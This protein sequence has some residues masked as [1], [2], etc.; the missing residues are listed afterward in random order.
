MSR[1]TFNE[2]IV[3]CSQGTPQFGKVV[4]SDVLAPRSVTKFSACFWKKP[5]NTSGHHPFKKHIEKSRLNEQTF[6]WKST[7]VRYGC[8]RIFSKG[9]PSASSWTW[10][11]PS[12]R[13]PKAI[14]PQEATSAG[15][16]TD[17][18]V[19][20]VSPLAGASSQFSAWFFAAISQLLL[21]PACC[22]WAFTYQRLFY[23]CP[24]TAPVWYALEGFVSSFVFVHA[25][26]NEWFSV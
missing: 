19:G 7:S 12:P 6:L 26:L 10:G 13:I 20:G 24:C 15:R 9:G 23:L 16:R 2:V 3:V 1:K 5:G 17:S 22:V 11:V 4:W 21:S 25:A 14:F 8:F 18:I